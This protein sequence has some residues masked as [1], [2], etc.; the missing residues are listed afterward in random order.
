VRAASISVHD[1]L[2]SD[3]VSRRISHRETTLSGRRT[4]TSPDSVTAMR[5]MLA[6]GLAMIACGSRE[7]DELT[8]GYAYVTAVPPP[9]LAATVARYEEVQSFGFDGDPHEWRGLTRYTLRD[10][11]PAHAG[12][13]FTGWIPG[14]WTIEG[15]ML[16]ITSSDPG[17]GSL[18]MHDCPDGSPP[19][20]VPRP[21]HFV[22]AESPFELRGNVLHL[23]RQFGETPPRAVDLTRAN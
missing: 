12:C 6:L 5:W 15:G 10:D 4:S 1:L 14:S 23:E 2:T 18:E 9:A 11:A 22:R 7:P 21:P 3:V 13:S 16:V 8:G 20:T 19:R 17:A